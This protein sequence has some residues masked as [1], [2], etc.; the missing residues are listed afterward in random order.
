MSARAGRR[1]ATLALLVATAAGAQETRC[2]RGD[3]EVRSLTF[4]GNV[5]FSDAELVAGIVTTPS[6]WARRTSVWSAPS[7]VST[8]RSSRATSSD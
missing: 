8:S 7:T 1:L 2:E 3:V 4:G 6:S 5:A